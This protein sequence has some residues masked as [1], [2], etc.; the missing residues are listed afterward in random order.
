MPT[1]EKLIIMADLRQ[2]PTGNLPKD[3]KIIARALLYILENM[4]TP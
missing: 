3:T 2:V 1:E 4:E